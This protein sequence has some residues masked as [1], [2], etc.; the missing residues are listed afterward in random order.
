MENFI[1]PKSKSKFKDMKVHEVLKS[2]DTSSVRVTGYFGSLLVVVK[3]FDCNNNSD[4]SIKFYEKPELY[5]A[6]KSYWHTNIPV[7]DGNRELYIKRAKEYLQEIVQYIQG[8]Y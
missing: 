2:H 4:R 8:L 7:K 3:I 6:V 1:K 5:A